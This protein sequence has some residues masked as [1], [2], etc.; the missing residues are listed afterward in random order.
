[1]DM[2]YGSFGVGEAVPFSMTKGG[3][4]YLSKE[5][6]QALLASLNNK[7]P[8]LTSSWSASTG[9]AS[10][11]FDPNADLWSYA[12]VPGPASPGDQTV[13]EQIVSLAP[14]AVVVA[15]V[16]SV[17]NALSGAPASVVYGIAKN[18]TVAAML[19]G[20]GASL[21]IVDTSMAQPPAGT[22][23]ESEKKKFSIVTPIVGGGIGLLVG[24]PVGA[25]VGAG[26]GLA[27]E[28]VRTA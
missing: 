14:G 4:Q 9:A 22:P 8:Q 1:M 19:A 27:V 12:A 20:E 28:A 17:K 3:V 11:S 24:G 2:V 13:A 7:Y 16:E 26:I 18:A 21:A 23:S 25:A 6:S 10:P 5:T 15:D